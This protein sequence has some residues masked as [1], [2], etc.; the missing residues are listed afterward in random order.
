MK[1]ISLSFSQTW[2]ASN[3]YIFTTNIFFKGESTFNY[4]YI[5]GA[6]AF[7][8]L[9]ET[10]GARNILTFTGAIHFKLKI[11]INLKH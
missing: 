5:S 11:I 3:I 2:R 1:L 10:L 7:F 8:F 4:Y 9:S 6:T